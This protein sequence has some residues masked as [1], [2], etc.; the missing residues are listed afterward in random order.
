MAKSKYLSKS[1]TNFKNVP[2]M[3][4]PPKTLHRHN[5][6]DGSLTVLGKFFKSFSE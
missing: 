1:C 3:N 5:I 4:L 2:A 6:M